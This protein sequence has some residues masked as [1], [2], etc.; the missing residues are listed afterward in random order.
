MA[1]NPSLRAL[2]ENFGRGLPHFYYFITNVSFCNQT[3]CY[4]IVVI[5]SSNSSDEITK[6]LYIN[7]RLNTHIVIF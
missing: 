1:F 7:I 2:F 5:S 4:K 3:N 6:L